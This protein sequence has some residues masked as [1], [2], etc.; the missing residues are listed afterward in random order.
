MKRIVG[1]Y[2]ANKSGTSVIFGTVSTAKPLCVE[3]DKKLTL[4]QK[5]LT[6]AQHLTD[7]YIDCEITTDDIDGFFVEHDGRH[8]V[9][10]EPGWQRGRILLKNHLNAGDKVIIARMDGGNQYVVLDRLPEDFK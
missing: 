3:I 4:T 5:F 8:D 10:V 1:D 7:Y 6:V 2:D 9:E